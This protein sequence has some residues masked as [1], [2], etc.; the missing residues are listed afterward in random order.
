M[1]DNPGFIRRFF[2]GVWSII[3]TSRKVILN[4][5][6]IAIILA[7][8]GVFS[9]DDHQIIVPNKSALVLDIAGDIVEQKVEVDPFDALLNEAFSRKEERPEVLLANVIT[10]I[11]EA[12]SDPRIAAMVLKLDQVQSASLSKLQDIGA[13]LT[14]FK[15]SGKPLI[16]IGAA[17]SQGQYYLASY[18]DE[19]WLD[20]KGFLLLDGFGRYQL[21]FKSALEKLSVS[22]HVF[23]V[24]TYKSAVEP[25]IRDDMSDEAKAA[26]KLWLSDLWHQYKQDVSTQRG[27]SIDNFDEDITA[28]LAKFES[29]NGSYAEYAL[30]NRWVDQL[31][32]TQEMT[33]QLISMV[34]KNEQGDS[35]KQIGFKS[36]LKAND[37]T[38]TLP[39]T[40]RNQV[41]VIVAKGAILDGHQ[42]PGTIGGEST[43]KLLKQARY[44]NNVKAVVLRVDS[45]GGSAYASDVIRREV[46]LLKKSGKPV[47]ASMGSVAASGG[48][49]IS[50]AADKIVAAPTTITGSIGIFGMFMTLENT[51]E[52]VGVF[53]DGVGTTDISGLSL[54]R[55]LSSGMAELFQMSINRGYQDF[56]SLVAQNRSM[57]NEQ[58]DKIAQ[59]RVWSGIKAHEIGLV[60]ELGTLEDAVTIAAELAELSDYEQILIEKKPSAQ[61]LFWQNLLDTSAQ[62]LPNNHSLKSGQTT[63]PA[64]ALFQQIF[65]EVKK[66]DQ[67]NDPQGIYSFCLT[68]DVN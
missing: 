65:S 53:T 67:F 62:W 20:P 55:P 12:A 31:K 5:I 17:Y 48:Y 44:D 50:A 47:V 57:T 11:D 3:D 39:S 28:L 46:D 42:P 66:L 32:T 16:A 43:A 14:K 2:S 36:Y 35:F 30:Q 45:P 61:D 10:V 64:T 21:Y 15:A 9:A 63:G 25:Y 68:C 7:F 23:R 49:W 60:D 54:T 27:F 26:N 24:G 8:F 6:F 37:L 40:H 33:D 58:V 13:A 22:Q 52:K 38:F 29:A 4:L 59:G 56:I 51:L 34:G 41:A 1:S 19:I 18:A